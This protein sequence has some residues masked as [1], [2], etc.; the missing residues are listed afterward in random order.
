MG[1]RRSSNEHDH[2]TSLVRENTSL[3]ADVPP[4]A[5]VRRRSFVP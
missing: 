1:Y 3:L 4:G 5:L 2:W